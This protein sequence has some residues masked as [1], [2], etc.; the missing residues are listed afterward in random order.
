[1]SV[2]GELWEEDAPEQPGRLAL[3]DA[4]VAPAAS[5]LGREA[6]TALTVLLPTFLL[7]TLLQFATPAFEAWPDASYACGVLVVT[8]T[9]WL[10]WALARRGLLD[11]AAVLVGVAAAAIGLS[12]A[13]CLL[14]KVTWTRGLQGNAHYALPA[15]P[16]SYGPSAAEVEFQAADGVRLRATHLD[17]RTPYAVV[18]VP[19]WRAN[20]ASFATVTLA[21]WLANDFGVL[22]LDPRGQGDSGGFKTPDGADRQDVLAAVAFLRSRGYQRIAVVAEQDAC[23][24]ATLAASER[25]FEALA[26]VGPTL[27]W[28]GGLGPSWSPQGL[29]GRL[30]WRVA[31]GL[32]LAAGRPER[33][34]AELVARVAPVPLMLVGS[35]AYQ[36]D[37]LKVL[38]DRAGD[39]AGLFV[40]RGQARPVDWAHFAEYHQFLTQWLPMA[41]VPPREPGAPATT[42]PVP[43]GP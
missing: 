32:R 14:A 42:A 41:L 28:G 6:G 22:V 40:W 23:L 18:I 33:P 37:V 21:T 5:L 36:Q 8:L 2:A 39:R 27:T 24:A 19:G 1:L 29:F 7:V 10:G 30:H 38:Q 9:G 16:V 20:R 25:R 13:G 4:W 17:N 15:H 12:A 43:A 35:E 3:P 31:G 11:R 26:L 34:L